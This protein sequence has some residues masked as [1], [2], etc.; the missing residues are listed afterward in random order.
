M[1]NKEKLGRGLE[2]LLGEAIGIE[3]GEKV[4]RLRLTEVH[5]NEAQPRK[6]FEQP[7]M[8]SLTNSIQEHGILQPII[9]RPTSKGYKIIA[10]ERRW[11]ASQQL[12]LTEI[13]AIVKNVDA[14][15]TIELALV[16]NIQREDLNPMEKAAAYYE[17]KTNFG[18]TQEQIATKVGQDRSTVANTLRLLDLPEEVQGYV[19]RGTISMG[20]ARSLLSLKDPI[21]QKELTEKIAADGLSV[22]DVELIVSG[23]K[24]QADSIK[25]TK[26]MQ[27][28]PKLI[29]SPQILDLEDSL[30][31]AVGT[32]VSIME[33]KGKGKITI[34]FSNNDQFERIIGKL[35]ALTGS[36]T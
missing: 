17:L 2:S 8:E 14:L 16:E 5:P 11:R 20:H 7:Q 31:R 35:K 15:K 19:S 33:K 4:M 36:Y 25:E 22:R 18:L 21:K 28:T 23:K 32:K 1:A 10:G 29:K 13:P 27:L 12:G 9:V 30:R 24:D 3:T 6:Q 26:D 34:E